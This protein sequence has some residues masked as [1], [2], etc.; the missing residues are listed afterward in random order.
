MNKNIIKTIIFSF[1]LS[2]LLLTQNAYTQAPDP[3]SGGHGQ[4][5]NR[6]AGGEAPI[7][8][9]LLI[10]LGLGAGYGVKKLYD[11]K[12]KKLLD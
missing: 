3:P 2:F 8:G 1:V 11:W 9:G 12:K 5:G 10:L 7:G 4:D 6:P